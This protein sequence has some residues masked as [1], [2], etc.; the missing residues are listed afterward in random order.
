M[1]RLREHR[2]NQWLALLLATGC[3]VGR[4]LIED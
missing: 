1:S 3:D 4:M 2:I